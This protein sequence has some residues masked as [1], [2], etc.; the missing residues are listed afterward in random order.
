[1]AFLRGHDVQRLEVRVHVHAQP[2][3]LLA[4]ELGGDVGRGFGKV[5]H[6]AHATPPR[7]TP[8]GGSRGSSWPWWAIPPPPAACLSCRP[9]QS[10]KGESPPFSPGAPFRRCGRGWIVDFACGAVHGPAVGEQGE[11]RPR[12]EPLALRQQ[13]PYGPERVRPG[14]QGPFPRRRG[15]APHRLF[16]GYLQPDAERAGAQRIQQVGIGDPPAAG[17]KDDPAFARR[18]AP[19][20]PPPS[21]GTPPRPRRRRSRGPGVPPR[22]RSRG[23]G[24][25][26]PT[27]A[28]PPA[29]RPPPTSPSTSSPPGRR[30][31]M[32][33]SARESPHCR[34]ARTR[35]PVIPKEAP[36]RTVPHRYSGAD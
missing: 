31:S 26:A 10:K 36:H 27:P 29:P 23:P 25:R 15:R 4:L 7:G 8:R 5:A 28:A 9:S 32:G 14:E 21:A 24:P 2:R 16:G 19:W 11:V 6:V 3:P 13:A 18:C 33:W 34:S 20:P 30:G 1:M 17:G 12:V 35:K 22:A